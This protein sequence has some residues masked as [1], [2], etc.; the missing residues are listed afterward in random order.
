MITKL[1]GQAF[2]TERWWDKLQKEIKAADVE[3]YRIETYRDLLDWITKNFDLDEAIRILTGTARL[4][5]KE[6]QE[7]IEEAVKTATFVPGEWFPRML[8]RTIAKIRGVP[9]KELFVPK[10]SK[11]KEGQTFIKLDIKGFLTDINSLENY[12]EKVRGSF[13]PEELEEIRTRAK[14]AIEDYG[15]YFVTAE[16]KPFLSNLT[17]EEK[18]EI[19]GSILQEMA[20]AGPW[21]EATAG[22]VIEGLTGIT[23]NIDG[24][25]T[26]FRENELKM[27]I[28]ATE[29]NK[30]ALDDVSDYI[31]TKL[32]SDVM[33]KIDE[34][35]RQRINRI[36]G[37]DI[38]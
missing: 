24:V 30:K 8:L 18:K 28:K 21:G 17:T 19:Y 36:F 25:L 14:K 11:E 7:R 20:I 33:D 12:L 4:P 29:E 31:R 26:E 10:P 6:L 22:A 38:Y 1:G 3:E 35:S 15:Y 2:T 16:M 9:E 5:G 27:V 13:T 37:D 23:E 34:E 32:A